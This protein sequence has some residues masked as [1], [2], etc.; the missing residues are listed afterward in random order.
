MTS[1]PQSVRDGSGTFVGVTVLQ[2]ALLDQG[3]QVALVAPA[4]GPMPFG[5]AVQRLVFNAGAGR[6]LAALD[7]V[8]DGVVGFDLDGCL[9]DRRRPVVAAIK[10]VLAEEL[11]FERGAVRFSLW[12]QSRF[13]RLN[14]RRAALVLTTSQYARQAIARHYRVSTARIAVVP[15]LID[16]G[17]WR[18]ALAAAGPRA[19]W[20]PTILTVCHLY[21]RK[22]IDVLLRAMPRVLRAVPAARLQIVGVGPETDRL[23]ALHAR[24]GLGETTTLLGHVPFDDLIRAY[25]DCA[26]FCLPSRQEGFGIVLLEAMAAGRPIV[27]CRAAAVPEVAPDG[28]VSRLVAPDD[29][30]ALAAALIDLLLDRERAERLGRQGAARV[31]IYDAPRVAERFAATIAPVMRYGTA[32]GTLADS[33]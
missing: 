24:L 4:P 7:P 2:R 29:P 19:A 32:V 12:V 15:E 27:G 16:L 14:V 13:E 28:E 5:H 26:V 9:L 3:H 8:P 21:P 23:R 31:E 20:T 33:S 17:R 10:G 1:T 25:R 22:R 11:T 6:R 30:A 18:A